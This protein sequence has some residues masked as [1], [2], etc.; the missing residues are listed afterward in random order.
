M[1]VADHLLESITGHLSHRMLEHYS[2]IRLDAKRKALDALDQQ[3]G[4]AQL[5]ADANYASE[6]E[7]TIET[8]DAPTSQSGFGRDGQT[9]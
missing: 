1:G 7:A 5:E 4:R 2:H 3:R 8:A 6:I 9:R